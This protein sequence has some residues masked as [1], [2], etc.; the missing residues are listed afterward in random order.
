MAQDNG[1]ILTFKYGIGGVIGFTYQGVGDFYYKKNIFGDIIG[2]I[3]KNGQEIAKYTYDAWGY[4]K[5]LVLN[6]N[7]YV[8]ILSKISYTTEGSNNKLIAELNPF[9]Y[10][11]Y[12]YDVET[13]LYY[14]NS[15]YYD[16]EIGRFINADNIS[17]LSESMNLIN[18]LNLFAYCNNNPIMHNDESG[19]AWWDWLWKGL[20]GALIVVAITAAVV[21]TAGAA[22][23]AFGATIGTTIGI[24]SG[25]AVGGLV[26]G[27]MSL[28]GQAVTV[29]LDNLNF[30]TLAID[31]FSGA[32]FG[33]ITGG[34]AS[35]GTLGA[36]IVGGVSKIALSGLTTSLHGINN[37]KSASTI[38][39]DVGLSMLLSALTQFAIIGG[40]LLFKSVNFSTG[41]GNAFTQFIKNSISFIK[42]HFDFRIFIIKTITGIWDIISGKFN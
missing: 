8:D 4:H 39:K 16:P 42:D 3:D 37:G 34:V 31:T 14:L 33:G 7:E 40:G 28:L 17:I 36:Q 13:G 41:N 29:G 30:G 32:I 38:L 11:G 2:I 6:N 1:N 5:T 24:M 35:I 18:G 26:A 27:G 15:R 9:R 10:R 22:A 20:L 25:V 12:Y 23:I 19:A 21:F